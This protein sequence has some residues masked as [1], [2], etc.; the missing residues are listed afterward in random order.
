MRAYTHEG[1]AH[2]QRVSTTFLTRKNSQIFLVLLAGFEPR[3]IGSRVRRS[4]TEPP[5][6]SMAALW[7]SEDSSLRQSYRRARLAIEE[8]RKKK[9]RLLVI[10]RLSPEPKTPESCLPSSGVVFPHGMTQS[11]AQKAPQ[12]KRLIISQPQA[13]ESSLSPSDDFHEASP[14]EDGVRLP[15]W[16]GN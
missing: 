13:P 11:T 1:W 2:R 7:P 15:T 5:R 16:Q 4:T 12:P 14:S 10:S 6:H 8:E 9:S 3:S